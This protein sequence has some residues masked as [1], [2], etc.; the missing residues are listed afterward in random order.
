MLF[1]SMYF[2]NIISNNDDDYSSLKNNYL[3][4]D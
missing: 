2:F 1:F 3:S 4:F